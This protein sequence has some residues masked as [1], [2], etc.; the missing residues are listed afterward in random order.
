MAKADWIKVNPSQG[1]GNAE[2][3]VSS[4]SEHTG[5]LARQSVLTFKAANVANVTRNVIQAGKPEFVDIE[6]A[7]AVEK[8]GKTV[9]I[10]GESNSKKL[11]FSLGTGDLNISVPDSYLANSLTTNNGVNI[12]GDPG[13]SSVYPFS[14]QIV[15]PS[16][17]TTSPMSRQLIVT[18]EAGKTDVCNITLA[19]GDAYLTVTMGDINLDYQGT[20]VTINVESN[21]TW[22]I[23]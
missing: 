16:N 6:D 11:T 13:A 23:E 3:S 17:E 18:N 19:S 10:S 5:R 15:V 21:T 2:V 1:S 9:T 4:S 7:M 22:T 14:I 8:A 20:P 12:L